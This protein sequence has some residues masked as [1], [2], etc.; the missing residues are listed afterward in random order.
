[1]EHSGN[2][3]CFNQQLEINDNLGGKAI[4]PKSI[5][6]ILCKLGHYYTDHT[7]TYENYEYWEFKSRFVGRCRA[8]TKNTLKKTIVEVVSSSRLTIQIIE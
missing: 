7:R 8:R 2:D 3:H 5:I 6:N 4:T 1:M